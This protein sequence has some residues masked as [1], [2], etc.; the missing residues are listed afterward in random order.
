MQ[1]GIFRFLWKHQKHFLRMTK[2]ILCNK[3]STIEHVK[4]S[5]MYVY[6]G[7]WIFLPKGL[8]AVLHLLWENDLAGPSHLFCY[9]PQMVALTQSM[10]C[11]EM[12]VSCFKVLGTKSFLMYVPKAH[13]EMWDLSSP[14]VTEQV[15]SSLSLSPGWT[16]SLGL[17]FH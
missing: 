7:V 17:G 1:R 2:P 16:V 8:M 14:G 12:S 6:T 10:L 13:T 9:M 3:I 15:R 11:S 4:G 5:S